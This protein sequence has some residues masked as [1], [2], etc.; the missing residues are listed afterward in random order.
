MKIFGKKIGLT[1]QVFLAMILGAIFG[2]VI[3][4]P[5]TK[6]GF[7]GDIW[8]NMIK[9]IV[10]PMVIVTIVTGIVSQKDIKSLGR[11]S[12]RIMA[13]YVVTT[14]IAAAIGIIVASIIKPGNIANFTG[15]ASKE[16]VA[17]SDITMEDFFLSMFSSNMFKSFSDGNILQTLIISVLIGIAILRMKTENMKTTIV[18]GFNSLSEMVFSLIGMIM[19]ASPI[20]V[21]FLM[22]DSFATYGAGI[23]TSMA[24]LAGTYYFACIVHIVFIYGGFLWIKA[25]VNPIRFIKDS[26]ELWIYTISTCSSVASIPVNIKV[27]KEKFGVSESISGFTVPLGSQ[28]NYDGSVLLYGVVIVFISQVVGVPL[29]I[30]TMLKVILLSAIFS[31]GGGGIPGSGIV[32]LLVMVE[33]FGLPTEIV[34]IIAAFYRLFDMG[35]TT[36]NCLGDLAGTIFVSK[37][38]EKSAAKAAN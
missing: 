7:I 6:V 26:A 9:M 22:A 32:K 38:E 20:G 10:V 18:N 5:M 2:L 16:V 28:M 33:A 19:I 27:A 36:N 1:T 34:G 31:T 29:S 30:G 37:L 4:E 3:G 14:L 11:I 35:T 12:F 24:T 13:Y 21:F 15:L 17:G 25:G 8:L 23:F